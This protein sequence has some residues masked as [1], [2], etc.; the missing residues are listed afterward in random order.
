MV[1]L[2]VVVFIIIIDGEGGCCGIIV[3]VVC[4]VID[5]LFMILVCINCGSVMYDVFKKNGWLC[6]NVFLDELEQL[7]M[8]F[9]GVIKVLMEECFGWDI[10]EELGELGQLVLVDVLVKLQGC[11]CDFKE[12]GMYLVMFVELVEVEVNEKKDSF[13]YFNWLFYKVKCMVF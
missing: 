13:I 12:V 11:I 2:L 5:M 9:F 7:V 1:Y 6:V 3:L 4:L 10:W 8:Y